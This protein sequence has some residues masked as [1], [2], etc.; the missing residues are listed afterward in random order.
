MIGKLLITTAL[1]FC[2]ASAGA[3]QG[4]ITTTGEELMFPGATSNYLEVP[5]EPSSSSYRIHYTSLKGRASDGRNVFVLHG[6][7]GDSD[8]V[9]PVADS[10]ATIDPEDVGKVNAV[11]GLD[12]PGHGK[13]A[14]PSGKTLGEVGLDDYVDALDAL[15]KEVNAKS[16]LPNNTVL[17][18]HSMGGI[19]IQV[20]AER[21]KQ[22]GLSLDDRG[23]HSVALFA[24]TLP[25][26]VRWSG[27]LNPTIYVT[28]LKTLTHNEANGC[29]AQFTNGETNSDIDMTEV[30]FTDRTTKQLYGYGLPSTDE[31][32]VFN[33]AQPCAAGFEM[34]G[35]DADLKRPHVSEGV[36]GGTK[37]M[38]VG[39]KGD[40]YMLPND[41]Q[42]MYQYL[43][44]VT[45]ND[46]DCSGNLP[47]TENVCD[48]LPGAHSS[49]W[50][51]ASDP[52]VN[53]APYQAWIL[54]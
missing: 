40:E 9:R 32:A 37:T 45:V 48:I 3:D 2:S 33:N 52:D 5:H 24:S 8:I 41:I 17:I 53:F 12:L 49:V 43:I 20:L 19:V 38:I 1:L 18:G 14:W 42:R 6:M 50:S 28:L 21:L 23:V 46:N 36:F 39:F 51:M 31:A 27:G 7:A 54:E 44:D 22:Q 34:L 30:F 13:S 10:F 25:Q 16:A 15:L 4:D 26:D 11:Y 35:L 29:L 47:G